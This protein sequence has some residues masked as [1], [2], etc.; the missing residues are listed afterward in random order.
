MVIA[1]AAF[2][3]TG[4]TRKIPDPVLIVFAGIVGLLLT[5]VRA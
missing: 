1:F 5:T 3:I 4:I 2:G